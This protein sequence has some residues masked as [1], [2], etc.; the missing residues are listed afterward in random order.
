MLINAKIGKHAYLLDRPHLLLQPNF[1]DNELV[2]DNTHPSSATA[3]EAAKVTSI[4]VV[5]NAPVQPPQLKTRDEK[6]S[7]LVITI[8][9]ME[10][11]VS[12]ILLNHKSLDRIT[13]TK[14]HDLDVKVTELTTIFQQIQHEV[15]SVKI[16]CSSSDDDDEL[17]LPTTTPFRTQ[18]R[19]TI[20]PV[21][22]ERP[23]LLAQASAPAPTPPVSTP[24]ATCAKAF[25][26]ALLSTPS[27]TTRGDRT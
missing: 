1:E 10:K 3:R 19:S 27:S 9:G 20:V 14:F 18:K 22:K 2:M 7:F 21:P 8:Q 25:V 26:D 17:P 16:P 5:R 15:D 24:P 23:C 4:E 13:E 12:E 11:K 6:M